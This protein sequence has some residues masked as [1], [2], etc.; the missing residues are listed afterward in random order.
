MA[1]SASTYQKVQM[2]KATDGAPKSSGAAYRSR[3][4]LRISRR[5]MVST[6]ATKR[7]S[8]AETMPSSCSSSTLAS[9]SSVSRLPV[10][11]CSALFQARSRIVSRRPSAEVRHCS[12]RSCKSEQG[13]RCGPAGRKPPSTWP[14]NACGCG[15]GRDT[16]RCRRPV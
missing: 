16:P 1:A 7:S 8:D 5:P 4:P 15:R 12:A 3:W 6:V 2:V 13:S 9:I 14:P 10:K 11:H